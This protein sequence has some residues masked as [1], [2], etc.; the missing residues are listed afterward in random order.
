MQ[1]YIFDED[2][3]G[4]LVLD[5]LL[6][7]ARRGVRVRLLIDQLS[8]LERRRHARRAGGVHANFE[9][10]IY[11]PMLRPRAGISYS[12][13]RAG[14]GVLLAPLNQRM[15][16]KL[17]LVDGA[18]GITGGRNYQD[19]YYD[20]DAEYNFRDRDVLVAGPA[21]ARDGGRFR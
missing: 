8:A 9:M 18:V 16:T 10:R 7:A 11:N 3:A 19:D 13:I 5:E 4:R 15:H 20:W 17:L 12:A 21:V 14:R 2:D 1:T 6:A